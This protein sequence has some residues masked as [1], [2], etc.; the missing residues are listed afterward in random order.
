MFM[1]VDS[2][3][4]IGT[5]GIFGYT[6]FMFLIGVKMDMSMISTT[7]KKALAVGI[8]SLVAPL[9][10]TLPVAVVLW[11]A[12]IK[13]GSYFPYIAATHCLTPFPVIASLLA[14]LKILNSELGRLA[15]SSAIVSD[16][17]SIF[18]TIA[19]I[20]AKTG[21]QVSK[22]RAM[23]NM[24]SAVVFLLV[25]VYV[26]R[27]AMFWVVA[28]TPEGRPVKSAY[29]YAIILG[30]FFCGLSSD[31]FGQ[32]SIFGAFIFGLTVPDG[33]PLGS[34]L[35]E[36]LESLLSLVLMPIFM[37][38]CAMR[39]NL[40]WVSSREMLND[41]LANFIILFVSLIA[42]VGA[43][44]IP[45]VRYCNM[46]RK[47]ALALGLI[48]CAKGNVNVATQSFVKDSG[49]SNSSSISL[50]LPITGN[51]WNLKMR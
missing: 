13:N 28:Q 9:I 17:F 18:L 25:V 24:I 37:V 49:V 12:W 5:L 10:I 44:Y 4:I 47:D 6:L 30:L 36:K 3:H 48:M 32:Y 38:T 51:C 15:L 41:A 19:T 33:P 27:P 22:E 1:T 35:V 46:A 14:D 43:C 20:V 42:K 45:L 16:L 29:L 21:G 7:G 2:Q 40:W 8:L 50:C 31:F 26:L 34:A 11:Q 39:A 23:I